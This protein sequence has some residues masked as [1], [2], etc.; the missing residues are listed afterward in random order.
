[1][2]KDTYTGNLT[3]E[4]IR[5]AERKYP[6]ADVSMLKLVIPMLVLTVIMF[7]LGVFIL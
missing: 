1:M 4:D 7:T 3:E 2:N 5:A 6:L